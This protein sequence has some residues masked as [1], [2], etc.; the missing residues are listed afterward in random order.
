MTTLEWILIVVIVVLVII[1]IPCI[2]LAVFACQ[3]MSVFIPKLPS[4]SLWQTIVDKFR[5]FI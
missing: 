1:L 3:F 5:K 2:L 4:K